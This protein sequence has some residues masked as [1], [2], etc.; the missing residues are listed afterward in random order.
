MSRYQLHLHT[1]ALAGQEEA[2]HRWYDEVHIAEVLGLDGFLTGERFQPVPL[3]P[4]APAPETYLAIYEIETDDVGALLQQL[5]TGKM[6]I[7]HA[8]DTA[9]VRMELYRTITP[10]IASR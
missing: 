9:N 3:A 1:R 7:S 8:L 10:K 4:D 2:Y 6:D 5:N